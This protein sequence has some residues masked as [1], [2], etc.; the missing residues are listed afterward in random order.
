[1]IQV[2]DTSYSLQDFI[3]DEM[4][5]LDFTS[6]RQLAAAMEVAP[7]TVTRIL[8]RKKPAD[9]DLETLVKLANITGKSIEALVAIAFPDV[10]R[11]TQLR[12]KT[13][14]MAQRFE[15]LDESEQ[16]TVEALLN[17]WGK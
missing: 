17:Q 10:A 15:K 4:K 2:S 14:I 7:S 8:N 3:E 16:R 11:K 12:A 9:P 13:E 5:R 6:A 1:M